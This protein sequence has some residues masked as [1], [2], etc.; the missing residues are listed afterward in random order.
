MR[1][2]SLPVFPTWAG[3]TSFLSFVD[4]V[5]VLRWEVVMLIRFECWC[6]VMA[7]VQWSHRLVMDEQA[8]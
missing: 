7:F 3:L 4:G 1:H 6:L 2:C 8:Y 5:L